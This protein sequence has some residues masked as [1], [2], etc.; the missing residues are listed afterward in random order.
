MTAKLIE[1]AIH[2][3]VYIDLATWDK[4]GCNPLVI[5]SPPHPFLVK[6]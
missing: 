1:M 6:I 3:Q 4:R 2:S 5:F